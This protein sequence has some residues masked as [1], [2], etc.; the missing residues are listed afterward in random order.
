MARLLAVA[1]AVIALLPAAAHAEPAPFG[2]T[3]TPANGVRFCPTTDLA[4]RPASF[5]G[6]PIDV[7]VTLPA[8]GDGP[9]PTILLLHG[10]GQDKTAFEKL[11]GAEP[12]YT[13]WAFARQ[14]YAVVTPTARGYGNSCGKPSAGSP[15]CEQGFTRLGDMRYEVRDFQTLV[16]QLVDQGIVDA[17]HIGATGIS[18]GG[19]FSTM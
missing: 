13:N 2:H 12:G 1:V 16:G 17:R 8:T 14:G 5:D 19:G 3:C 9:F 15:G 4:S 18:Y 7:D 6:T 11:G 10:L